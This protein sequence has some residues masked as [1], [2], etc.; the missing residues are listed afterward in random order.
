MN[1]HVIRSDP[2]QVANIRVWV[3]DYEKQEENGQ[4]TWRVQIAGQAPGEDLAKGDPARRLVPA[5]KKRP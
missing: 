2:I 4:D 5:R 3:L 1:I